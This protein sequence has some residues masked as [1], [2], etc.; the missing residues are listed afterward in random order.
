MV[1]KSNQLKLHKAKVTV[2]SEICTKHSMQ[3]ERR[4]EFLN[5]KPGGT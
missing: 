3:R 4:V 1:V 5:I 2:S